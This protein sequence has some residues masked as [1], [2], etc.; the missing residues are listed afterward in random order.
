MVRDAGYRRLE[1]T[2]PGK[3][4]PLKPLEEGKFYPV[5]KTALQRG[6]NFRVLFASWAERAIKT[7]STSGQ[8]CNFFVF[9]CF[10]KFGTVLATQ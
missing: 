5:G 6:E 9:F 7:V 3:I 2:L 8:S 10:G 4:Y 1:G